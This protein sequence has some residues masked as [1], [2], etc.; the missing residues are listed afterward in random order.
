MKQPLYNTGVLFKTLIKRDWF[1]LVFWI[2]GMLAFAASGAGK[3]E[4]ASNPATA[5]TL[6]T[7]FVKNPAMV[8]LFGPTPINNP[9]NYSLGPIFGQTMT[10]IT[11][12]TFAIISIIYVVNRSRKEEDD[13]ITEFFGLTLLENWQIRLL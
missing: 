13:G 11:G 3:M 7:M 1:K 2:L 8:G 5:S 9:A 10:L 12:L 4:V 6:Y